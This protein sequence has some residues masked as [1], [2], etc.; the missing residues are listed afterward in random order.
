MLWAFSCRSILPLRKQ[1]KKKKEKLILNQCKS[2]LSLLIGMMETSL[3]CL[4]YSTT[5]SFKMPCPDMLTV[6]PAT[7]DKLPHAGCSQHEPQPLLQP[8]SGVR[9]RSSPTSTESWWIEDHHGNS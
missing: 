9:A 1:N 3:I 5:K 2:M 4:L 7:C 6:L 8:T